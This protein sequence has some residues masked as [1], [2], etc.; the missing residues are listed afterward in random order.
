MSE[1]KVTAPPDFSSFDDLF[2]LDIHEGSRCW[3][4]HALEFFAIGTAVLPLVG[5]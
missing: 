5:E 1:E 3:E 4:T 2:G